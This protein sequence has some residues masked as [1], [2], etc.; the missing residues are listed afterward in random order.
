[1]YS[2]SLAFGAWKLP[3]NQRWPDLS[4]GTAE[5]AF[6]TGISENILSF[7]AM[8]YT[9]REP[10]QLY[11]VIYQKETTKKGKEQRELTYNVFSRASYIPG[12]K[13]SVNSS[14]FHWGRRQ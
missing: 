3:W 1:M 2:S 10:I 11:Y 14:V 7:F 13:N 8:R 9:C 4:T 12:P 6:K 5:M